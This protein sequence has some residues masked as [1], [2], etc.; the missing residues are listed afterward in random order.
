ML[1]LST[2]TNCSLITVVPNDRTISIWTDTVLYNYL[3][4]TKLKNYKMLNAC[5]IALSESF[6]AQESDGPCE[7][8]LFYCLCLSVGVL[9]MVLCPP[10]TINEFKSKL[11][12]G[13]RC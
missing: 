3:T 2:A 10:F 9:T 11:M 6:S 4:N 1:D 8:Q 12:Y 13:D 7:E 5:S